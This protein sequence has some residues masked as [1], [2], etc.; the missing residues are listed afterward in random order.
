MF[1]ET[2]SMA[3]KTLTNSI[4]WIF[5]QGTVAK[6]FSVEEFRKLSKIASP[7]ILVSLV[8]M[9]I[10][11]TDVIVIGKLGT[12]ELAAGA[13]ASDFYSIF[14]Y[15]AAGVI[16]A[17]SPLIAQARGKQQFRGIKSITIPGLLAG[18]ITGIPASIAVYHGSYFLGLIGVHHEIVTAA[19]PYSHM[20]AI[21][22]F[23][24]LGVM[25]MHHFLSAHGNTKIILYI[26]AVALPISALGNYALLYGNL[27]FPELGLA[28]AGIATVITGF[29][30]FLSMVAYVL[31]NNRLRRYLYFPTNRVC[32]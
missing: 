15:L 14:F 29:L 9:S 10:S 28:G 12:V 4:Y 7:L 5:P 1:T 11:I 23:S 24:M 26:T 16:A 32:Y 8:T 30:M 25:A 21:A 2:M 27:G 31:N 19:A 22:I 3:N 20:M 6:W 18:L 13:A 17:I